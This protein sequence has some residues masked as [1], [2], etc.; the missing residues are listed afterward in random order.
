[1]SEHPTPSRWRQAAGTLAALLGLASA[2]AAPDLVLQRGGLGLEELTRKSSLQFSANYGFTRVEYF[3]FRVHHQGKPVAVPDGRGGRRTEFRDA[4]ALTGAPWPALLVHDDAWVLISERD[5]QLRIE[6]LPASP[7]GHSVLQWADREQQSVSVGRVRIEATPPEALA[8][9]GGRW[10]LLDG[11]QLLDLQTLRRQPL[12]LNPPPGYQAV[13][14]PVLGVSPDGRALALL[15][16]GESNSARDALIVIASTEGGPQQLL[17][18]DLKALTGQGTAEPDPQLLARHFRWEAGTG[19]A[20]TTLKLRPPE[21]RPAW[22][23][24][25][26]YGLRAP[27]AESG[28]VFSR[29][30]LSPVRPSMLPAVRAYLTADCGCNFTP[31]PAAAGAGA[32]QL[33]LSTITTTLRHDA[34]RQALVIEAG[35]G[36]GGPLWAQSV[37]RDLGELVE[38]GLKAGALREHLAGGTR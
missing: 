36:D 4:W 12:V 29:F 2:Q 28:E 6:A 38:A 8:L 25:Y 31:A 11:V 30:E 16:R 1:M 5:G 9:A 7:T 22:Q 26:L 32:F 13:S 18:L 35:H 27:R 24:R 20:A 21:H 37:T 14:S 33:K 17:P 15:H 3:K 10:L 23:A 34:A 19:G